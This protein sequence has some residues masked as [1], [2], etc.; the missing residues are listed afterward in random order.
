MRTT[1]LT[2]K[3]VAK[4]SIVLLF[5]TFG[6]SLLLFTDKAEAVMDNSVSL[7]TV[8]D[9]EN[10]H[11]PDMTTLFLG[12]DWTSYSSFE[13]DH[14]GQIKAVL[15]SPIGSGLTGEVWICRE[16]PGKN[17][18]GRISQFTDKPT[19]VSWFL[20]SGTYYIYA[21][22]VKPS[23]NVLVE[24]P[25][26][27]SG[28]DI[29][30]ALLYEKAKIKEID[31]STSFKNNHVIDHTN[32]VRGFLTN[33]HPADYYSFH[34][35]EKTS[36]TIKYSFENS[37]SSNE[38]TGYC[39]LYDVNELSLQKSSYKNE[40][41]SVKEFTCLL[42]A[43]TYYIKLSGLLGNTT[44]SI[45]RMYYDIKL[46]P[47]TDWG[48]TKKQIKVHIDTSID[49]T[50]IKVLHY[51]VKTSLLDNNSVWSEN[52]KNYIPLD[53]ETF[54]AKKSGTYSVRITDKNGNNTMKKLKITNIDVTKPAIKGVKNKKAYKQAVT[55]TWTD[56]Q[57]GIDPS[58][59]TLNG[60]VITSGTTITKEGKYTL[61]VYDK[62]GNYKKIEFYIDRSKPVAEIENGKTYTSSFLVMFKDSISGIKR[63]VIDG[64]EIPSANNTKYFYLDGQYVVELWDHAG[65]H[66]KYKFTLK[67]E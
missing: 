50:D 18:T 63:I 28:P 13:I 2:I 14:P 30:M 11:Y 58:R 45:E 38:E 35:T 67:K 46:T 31:H 16:T 17:I 36:V 24:G 62:I 56:K 12:Y 4:V 5:L 3:K 10:Y 29:S 65:N 54:I 57:S 59:T 1:F 41:A 48:W 15:H 23:S 26:Y 53:G 7:Q 22:I 49:Y 40:D 47:V 42:E 66:S 25:Y 34:L 43:G 32:T 61:K 9:L 6:L 51:N 60:K 39:T 21:K 64:E 19:E 55:P 44:L 37:S 8:A 33:E 27:N 20:E 52:N